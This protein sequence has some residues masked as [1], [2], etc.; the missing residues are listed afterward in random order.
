MIYG[1]RDEKDAPPPSVL[2]GAMFSF[3]CD[4]DVDE[5]DDGGAGR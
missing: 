3:S 5:L 4:G 1:S 2:L